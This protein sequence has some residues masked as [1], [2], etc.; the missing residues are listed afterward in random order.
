VVAAN[1]D[2][3]PMDLVT[4]TADRVAFVFAGGK[5]L[6]SAACHDMPN[7]AVAEGGDISD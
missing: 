3:G 5:I 2:D 6:V 7:P 4:T 1:A